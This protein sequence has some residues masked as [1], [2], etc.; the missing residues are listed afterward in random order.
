MLIIRFFF[1]PLMSPLAGMWARVSGLRLFDAVGT[2]LACCFDYLPVP[3]S[4][5]TQAVYAVQPVITVRAG[6]G[7]AWN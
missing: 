7:I 6:Y 5:D 1:A 4:T 2:P 3:R